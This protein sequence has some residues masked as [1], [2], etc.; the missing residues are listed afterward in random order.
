MKEIEFEVSNYRN[1]TID[2]PLK[3]CVKS[4]ISCYLGINNIGKS[5]ILKF[6]FELDEVIALVLNSKA[7]N[8][9]IE[10][11]KI[12]I[13]FGNIK[14]RTNDIKVITVIIKMNSYELT[15]NINS[16]DLNN[17]YS[18]IVNITYNTTGFNGN[19][20]NELLLL[21]SNI[22]YI[23]PFRN[24]VFQINDIYFNFML[25]SQFILEW[26][27]WQG[28]DDMIRAQRINDFVN[29]LRDFFQFKKFK[30]FV[31]DLKTSLLVETD[32][33]LFKL[34]ELG[35]GIA[36]FIICLGNAVIKKPNIILIDEPELNL[37]PKLQEEFMRILASKANF[38]TIAA[39]HSIGLARSCA[40]HIYSVIRKENGNIH[41]DPY[42]KVR[43]STIE[44]SIYELGYS[45]WVEL[46]GTN[47]LL[48]EGRT[49]IKSF[50]E[51][52]R[53]FNIEQH[54][55]IMS[56]GGNDFVN[57]D[58]KAI[59]E[60]LSDLKRFNAPISVIFDSERKAKEEHLKPK[61]QAFKELCE[62]LSFKVFPTEYCSTENYIKQYAIDS[63]S[64]EI[65][66][67]ELKPYDRVNELYK[68]WPKEQNWLM[69]RNMKI[70][71]FDGTELKKFIENELIPLCK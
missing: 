51:I 52:L 28:G 2:N 40:D 59:S 32:D 37:H 14:N 63:L 16:S 3:F 12:K 62:E 26:S 10:S 47:I 13:P 38:A 19:T 42:G 61:L 22:L 56:L 23:P 69:F 36:Q 7:A 58:L 43:A 4:G 57:G 67:K 35:S 1:F 24:G 49:D 8:G 48:V 6:F 17:E 15:I 39:T 66:V 55:I 5:N 33:G 41:I 54:F 46:G 27:K 20:K 18:N 29:E 65:P 25:G 11:K 45:Q 64:K 44:Q 30:L 21:F 68:N 70:D 34:E 9:F 31:N 60:E 50:R 53:K 71:D